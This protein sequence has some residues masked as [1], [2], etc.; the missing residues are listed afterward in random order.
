[1]PSYKT[2]LIPCLPQILKRSQGL[3]RNGKPIPETLFADTDTGDEIIISG[4]DIHHEDVPGFLKKC[5][6]MN[7]RV[8]IYAFKEPGKEE[9]ADL[10]KLLN[11]GHV[12]DFRVIHRDAEL[13]TLLDVFNMSGHNSKIVVDPNNKPTRD[14]HKDPLNSGLTH[15]NIVSFLSSQNP[16]PDIP[17]LKYGE[18]FASMAQHLS[19]F[20][21]GRTAAFLQ[22]KQLLYIG[23]GSHSP[24][25]DYIRKNYEAIINTCREHGVTFTY[26][27]KLLHD[28]HIL[29]EKA[30][31]YLRYRFPG[32][33]DWQDDEI[34]KLI[35]GFF[36]EKSTGEIYEFLLEWMGLPA[37]DKPVLI[38]L[39][40]K[41]SLSSPTY[42]FVEAFNE[43]DHS[44]GGHS[45]D[46]L[47]RITGS[48]HKV[49]FSLRS[50]SFDDP[51][52]PQEEERYDADS[53]FDR[54]SKVL[55][56]EIRELIDRF[57]PQHYGALAETALYI[58]Q[59]MVAER[60]E[61]AEKIKPLVDRPKL[62]EK[63]KALSRLIISKH[64]RFFLP[65]YGNIEIK[66]HAL[67]RTVYLLF[68]RHPEA[69]R[70]KEL[71]EHR[72]ELLSIYQK[73]TNRYD[74][75]EIEQ[76]VDDLVD[77][78]KPSINQ[79]CARIRE[80]FR[81]V[82]DEDMAKHYYIDGANGHPKKIALPEEMII[83]EK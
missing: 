63:T 27:P 37:P 75:D 50:L 45:I 11:E 15:N 10:E 78:T 52:H 60:P 26:L 32:F 62:P 33:Y 13:S 53:H 12:D 8:C 35:S 1:M 4:T 80:A 71:C 21:L 36:A 3:I 39:F 7:Y 47:I 58:I 25:D 29:F 54:E 49:S 30:I 69:I 41:D 44:F 24:A 20:T 6:Q 61:L 46:Q 66:M 68:L 22:M 64:N 55:S 17:F 72:E 14:W 28:D 57:E 59:K 23:T 77:M 76:A 48:D 19:R 43:D 31:G 18:T 42:F 65:E 56:A 34:K 82:M 40:T 5:R 51:E 67:P 73:V 38:R 79:K 70:F 74:Q 16:F 81:K 2:I 9:Q 83:F